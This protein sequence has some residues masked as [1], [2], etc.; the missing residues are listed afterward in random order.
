[1]FEQVKKELVEKIDQNSTLDK[2]RTIWL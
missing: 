1:M 2:R